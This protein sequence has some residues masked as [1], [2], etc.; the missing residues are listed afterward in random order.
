MNEEMIV[1][2]FQIYNL[3]FSFRF[4]REKREKEIVQLVEL[5]MTTNIRIGRRND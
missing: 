5:K 1:R 4:R 3:S 2:R